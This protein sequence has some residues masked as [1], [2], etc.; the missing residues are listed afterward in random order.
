[1]Y[2]TRMDSFIA[3]AEA[4]SFSAAAEKLFVSRTALI[5]QINLLEKN[6]ELKLFDRHTKGVALTP[7]G[8]Y[9]YIE[10]KKF[11]QLSNK[12]LSSCRALEKKNGDSIRIGILPN[13]KAVLLPRI[14]HKF[15]EKYP[16]V[17]MHFIEYPLE[18]YFKNFES[19][20]F[21]ITTEYMMGYFFDNPDYKFVKLMEDTHCCGMSPNH[22][23]ANKKEITIE[24]LSNQKL[25]MYSRGITRAD[26][27]L[28]NY[29]EKN[30]P[31][32]TIL[33]I[34]YYDSSLPLKCE[35]E[36][37]ILIYYSM[38]WESFP[39]LVS[40]PLH[41]SMHFPIDIGFGYNAEANNAV[42][43]FIEFSKEILGSY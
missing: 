7:S 35:L 23:L 31:A 26:D 37:M 39:S 12:I 6:L 28:R 11:I 9:F 8:K 36:G 17:N 14:C 15:I 21:D 40:I 38:Y 4:G 43:L 1:M 10:A 20:H 5:K 13:F 33:D 22:P 24:D 30:A 16:N 19:H 27:K 32:A 18:N 42:K 29:I 3:I 25:I 34:N 2:D 41:T